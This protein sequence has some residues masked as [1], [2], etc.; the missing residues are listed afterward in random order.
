V[1]VITSWEAEWGAPLHGLWSEYYKTTPR[2]PHNT[3][4]APWVARRYKRTRR[5]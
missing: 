2:Q 5:S 3:E 4:L 1:Y